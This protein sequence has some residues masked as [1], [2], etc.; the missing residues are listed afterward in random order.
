MN[1]T[2]LVWGGIITTLLFCAYYP[3]I[4]PLLQRFGARDSYYSHGYMVPFVSAYLVWRKRKELAALQPQGSYWG[5]FLIIFGLL[6]HIASYFLR[7][8][9]TSCASLIVVLF[10]LSLLP[11]FPYLV[12]HCGNGNKHQR[13]GEFLLFGVLMKDVVK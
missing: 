10:G 7:T 8:N 5:L 6:V 11:L 13:H 9:I 1:K 4:E 12:P 2:I 3:I